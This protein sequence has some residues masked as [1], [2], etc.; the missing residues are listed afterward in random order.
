LIKA[1][2]PLFVVTCIFAGIACQAQSGLSTAAPIPV[3]RTGAT[4]ILVDV[5]VTGHKGLPVD[6]LQQEDFTV[7]EN[8]QPQR[9]VSF[10]AHLPSPSGSPA[11]QPLPSGVY[12]NVQPAP[13]GGAVDVL[14]IDALNTPVAA[15]VQAHRVLIQYLN[16]LPKG[17]AVAIFMLN[18]E[19]RQ[20][21]DFTTDHTAL[22]KAVEEFA[23][24]PEKSALL[25]TKED[26]EEE[27]TEEDRIISTAAAIKLPQLA[28][29][30]IQQLQQFDSERTSFNITLRVQYTL[31]A[32][33][34]LGR[35]L[36]GIPGRKNVMWLSGSFPIAILP[37][38]SLKNPQQA[39]RNFADAVDHTSRLL[40][41]ARV[42]LYPIDARGLF[43][44]T[45]ST[46][47]MGGGSEARTPERVSKGE[48][49][50]FGQN[51]EEQLSLEAFA[52][53]TG[54]EAIYNSNDLKGALAE[55]DRVG[56]HY[57]SLAYAPSNKSQDN[58]PRRID[59]RVRP[60]KYHLSYRRSYTPSDDPQR[61]RIGADFASLVQHDVPPSTQILFRVTPA[62]A[63]SQP[64][65][66]AAILGDNQNSKRPVTRIS[67]DWRV[68]TELLTLTPAADGVL[69]GATT[70]LTIAYDRDGKALNSVSNTL[71]INVPSA[72]Y[73][74]FVNGGIHY[75]QKLDIPAQAA[76]L[77]AGILDPVSG[78]V[79][80]LE[81]P[82]SVKATN[83]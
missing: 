47:A 62:R 63:A 21:E 69:H 10:E 42:A 15:Q 32:F 3:I 2:L 81:V 58:K 8:G 29:I 48:M 18:T 72:A 78:H 52:H 20:L 82:F 67:L 27:L 6:N 38:P 33:D 56:S 25:K 75:Q 40:A 71:A 12:T 34:R 22:L 44:A 14:L 49:D 39:A 64:D 70:L 4:N 60:G 37:D 45:L 16:T 66:M 11:A 65:T 43:P 24:N 53:L 41:N 7:F 28:G 77:R 73:P 13:E 1:A 59:V 17:K 19:L 80:T 30:Q 36:S 79:G 31:A 5:V 46:A 74:Q 54:G 9:I 55:V 57:Y 23:R 83:H 61:N 35:Y 76:W 68:D 51:A 26:T 50:E